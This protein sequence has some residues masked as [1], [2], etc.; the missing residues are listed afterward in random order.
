MR[1]F[2]IATLMMAPIMTVIGLAVTRESNARDWSEDAGRMG[3]DVPAMLNYHPIDGA[4]YA[5]EVR[6]AMAP[7]A[8]NP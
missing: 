1:K 6:S 5:G 3:G 2:L 7:T 8:V 4:S